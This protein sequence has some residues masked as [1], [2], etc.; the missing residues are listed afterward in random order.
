MIKNTVHFIA[1]ILSFAAI[2]LSLY[3]GKAK[4]TVSE[5]TTLNSTTPTSTVSNS[6]TP[7]PEPSDTSDKI[8]GATLAI[9]ATFGAA[10]YKT[11]FARYL[12]APETRQVSLILSLIGLI[13][14]LFILPISF[15]LIYFNVESVEWETA[16]WGLIIAVSF[17]GVIFNFLINY[18][19]VVTYP[20]FISV[21]FSLCLP[22]NLAI[23]YFFRGDNF[24]GLQLAGTAVAFSAVLLLLALQY[25]STKKAGKEKYSAGKE[26]EAEKFDME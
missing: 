1:S 22:G 9:L 4:S 3:G 26:I 19:V 11:I 17:S 7:I 21:G 5:N 16:P 10:F 13:N 24:T 8:I 23:D 2:I 12:K 14:L 15:L 18:G 20:L 6:T 25:W